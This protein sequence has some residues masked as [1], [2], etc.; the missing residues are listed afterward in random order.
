MFSWNLQGKLRI[1]EKPLVMGILNITSDS[2]YEGSRLLPEMNWLNTAEKMI[3]EG[4]DILDI[5]GQ[6]TRPGSTRI[7][8]EEELKRILP[9]VEQLHE[10]HPEKILSIDTY[11]SMVAREAVAAGACIV[12]DISG[13]EMDPEMIPL[14]GSLGVP[15]ICMHMQG[16]PENMQQKPAYENVVT[17][18]L[19]Y[20]FAKKTQCLQAGIHDLILDPGFGFGKTIEH[21]FQLLKDLNKFKIT[22][23]PI[24]AGLSRKST[25]YKTLGISP[26]EALNGSTVLNTIALLQG[27]DILRVHDVKEAKEAITLVQALTTN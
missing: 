16:R 8:A 2:F 25:I 20:F 17:D 13:G 15:F 7:S 6:S 4:A 10:R 9:V 27:A 19:H 5:G 1:V 26:A 21:S 22:G 11:Q 23:L 3:S 14:V 18:L 12:N 24:L